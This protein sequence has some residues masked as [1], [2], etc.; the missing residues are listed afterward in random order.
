MVDQT[1]ATLFQPSVPLQVLL[2]LSLASQLRF[3]I[4]L[5]VTAVPC[6][7]MV[8]F[9]RAPRTPLRRPFF[10]MPALPFP[11]LSCLARDFLL[12]FSSGLARRVDLYFT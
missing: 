12:G 10:S 4:P 3:L 6:T 11:S 9:R 7:L 5:G 1:P 2:G 8:G